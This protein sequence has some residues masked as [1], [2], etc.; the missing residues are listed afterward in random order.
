MP[1]FINNVECTKKVRV[2]I[3]YDWEVYFKINGEVATW[4]A[5]KTREEVA[6]NVRMCRLCD[7]TKCVFAER[8]DEAL[9]I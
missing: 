9:K 7:G 4:T 1:T 5:F 3:D 6:M 8:G 2:E